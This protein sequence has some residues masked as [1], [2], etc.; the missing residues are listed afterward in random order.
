MKRCPK[1][2][3]QYSD[4]SLNFCLQDGASLVSP[5]QSSID[6]VAFRQPVTAEKLFITQE[7]PPPVNSTVQ[8][9]AAAEKEPPA[10]QPV[11]KKSG[12]GMIAGF[13]VMP[14]LLLLTAGVGGGW[15]YL[16]AQK[17]V[18]EKSSFTPAAANLSPE[19]NSAGPKQDVSPSVPVPAKPEDNN[20]PAAPVSMDVARKQVGDVI[21]TWR[22]AAQGHKAAEYVALYGDKVEYFDE[23]GVTPNQIRARMQKIFDGY[24]EIDIE[25]TNMV[26]AID[27]E[28]DAA[29]ALFDKEW[30]Y[31]ASPKLSE[32]K[33]HVKLHLRKAGTQWKIIAEEYLKTYYT[34]N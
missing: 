34:E 6:T 16:S 3:S 10:V 18:S 5:N 8:I 20:K 25:L 14:L 17:N 33:A 31:E 13:V 15:W 22:L 12:A 26:I 28:G 19:S 1:C 23:H 2:N 27:A 11:Q 7:F 21:E 4:P 30:S 9:P 29:T 24:S 32:G